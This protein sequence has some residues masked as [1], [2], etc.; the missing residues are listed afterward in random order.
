MTILSIIGALVGV[1]FIAGGAAGTVHGL[2]TRGRADGVDVLIAIVG[3]AL[4]AFC[5][6]V[7]T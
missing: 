4:F 7:L 2:R 1:I 5:L 3:A 6:Q